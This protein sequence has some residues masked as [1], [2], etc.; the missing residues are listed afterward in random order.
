[1]TT[2]LKESIL[3]IRNGIQSGKFL[4]ENEASISQGIVLRILNS[5]S[6]PTFDTSIVFPE[7]PFE[8]G[9]VDYG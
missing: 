5:L 9:R 4:D 6:W 7:Y 1:M 8:G 2:S 3:D